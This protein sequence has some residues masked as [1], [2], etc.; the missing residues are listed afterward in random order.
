MRQVHEI[1]TNVHCLFIVKS[2]FIVRLV[3][4]MKQSMSQRVI[5]EHQIDRHFSA[6]DLAELYRFEPDVLENEDDKRPTPVIPKV[7]K[8]VISHLF[9][10]IA[11]LNCNIVL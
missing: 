7:I 6:N 2:P 1:K 5:D 9:P 11:V 3:Q 4:V 8:S 10:Q